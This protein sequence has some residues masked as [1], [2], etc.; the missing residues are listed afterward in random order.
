MGTQ[1]FAYFTWKYWHWDSVFFCQN[2]KSV[3]CNL[4]VERR[5]KDTEHTHT[6]TPTLIRSLARNQVAGI[7]THFN[8]GVNKV[9][10]S[11]R[12]TPP[13]C[14]LLQGIEQRHARHYFFHVK[15]NCQKTVKKKGS[16]FFLLKTPKTEKH[17]KPCYLVWS[18]VTHPS[19]NPSRSLTRIGLNPEL[20]YFPLTAHP[21]MFDSSRTVP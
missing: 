18:P 13:H 16:F 15:V 1:K 4:C 19:L 11:A 21:D 14:T 7:N 3:F 9:N 20:D 2:S 12:M 6:H 10:N 17:K 8:Q 5:L